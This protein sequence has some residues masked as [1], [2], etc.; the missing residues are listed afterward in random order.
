MAHGADIV[1]VEGLA[2]PDGRLHPVQAA[3]AE[4]NGSQCGFCTPGFVMALWSGF[5]AGRPDREGV[6]RLV[7]GNLCRCTG[8]GPIIEGA[9]AAHDRPA[10]DWERQAAEVRA[11]IEALGAD[12]ALA[13]EAAGRRFWSPVT[14][15]GLADLVATHPGAT[16]L[17]GATDVGLWITKQGFDP[18]E[19]IWTGR[20]AG[21][22]AI[23]E[24]D[25][26]LRIGA[27]ASYTDAR[28][29]IAAHYP[30]IGRLVDRIGGG[31]VRAMGTIGGNIANGSP[32]G[33]SP[34]A[35][36]AAGARL[37]L[38]A[39]TRRRELP[40][41]D[42]F[43]AYGRQDLQPGEFVE[44]VRLPLPDD[45]ARLRCYKLSKRFDQDITAVLGCF[46]VAVEDGRV[47]TARLAYGGMAGIPARALAAE[48][49]LLGKPWTRE[50]VAA[51]EAALAQD[52]EPMSDHRGSA[53]YRMRSA[54]ALLVKY[55][56]ETTEPGTA[57]RLREIA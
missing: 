17:S 51:A 4:A 43:L 23:E 25:G 47:V 16:I 36:I 57:T 24:E 48:M 7:S 49:E 33:D 40:L 20:V 54:R 5:A 12:G 45:G 50:T 15:D 26:H 41:E 21:L 10:S 34:P 22:A 2:A 46:D 3:I 19:V 30:D 52:F 53:A 38:R 28:D 44:A 13:F 37:V 8:Y 35:L 1:T 55:F 27:G 14:I 56:I 39:G 32:I 18:E 29:R 31:Q 11:G 6:E 42:F 9:I